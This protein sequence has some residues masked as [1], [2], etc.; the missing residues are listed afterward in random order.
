MVVDEKRDDVDAG[1]FDECV[2]RRYGGDRRRS[3]GRVIFGQIFDGRGI[4]SA[5]GRAT[6]S[7]MPAKRK[8]SVG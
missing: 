5:S 8:K 4:E 7:V 2:R 6:V 3:G 1:R